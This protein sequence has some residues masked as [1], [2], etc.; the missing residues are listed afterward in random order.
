MSYHCNIQREVLKTNVCTR[1]STPKSI[2]ARTQWHTGTRSCT[3]MHTR[4]LTHAHAF[5]SPPA[6]P[7]HTLLSHFHYSSSQ[8]EALTDALGAPLVPPVGLLRRPSSAPSR[9]SAEAQ[10]TLSTPELPPDGRPSAE[11][12]EGTRLPIDGGEGL[13]S[14]LPTREPAAAAISIPGQGLE[15]ELVLHARTRAHV[16]LE[17]SCGD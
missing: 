14:H 15:A 9:S 12:K 4:A 17:K 5:T 10:R 1:V 2:Y 3:H 13:A 16:P 8:V 7:T 6:T 11:R